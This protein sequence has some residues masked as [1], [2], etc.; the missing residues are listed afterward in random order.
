MLKWL[1]HI[2]PTPLLPTVHL[3]LPKNTFTQSTHGKN[4]LEYLVS[5]LS[6]NKHASQSNT[7]LHISWN[8]VWDHIYASYC[9]LLTILCKA[10]PSD[11]F[12][13]AVSPKYVLS[14]SGDS[15]VKLWDIASPEHPLVHSF[16]KMHPLG[17]HHVVTSG[18][19]RIAASAGY[20][21]E[22][23]LWDLQHFTPIGNL[24]GILNRERI[25]EQVD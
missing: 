16:A 22:T 25:D 23:L 2:C 7:S 19:G 10:H 3:P 18:D 12:A 17:V 6:P 9:S 24:G 1:A 5:H 21:G 8:R 4:P 20:G 13:L 14:A 11:I 15:S